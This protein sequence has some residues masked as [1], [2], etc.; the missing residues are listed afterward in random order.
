[1]E[2]ISIIDYARF[3]GL[4]ALQKGLTITPL[5]LQKLLYYEQAWSMVFFGRSA[6]LF[7]EKPQAW[8]NG[9]VYPEI[10]HLFN[11]K[12]GIYDN[13]EKKH[14]CDDKDLDL[15][16][17]I[18]IRQLAESMALNE[19]QLFLSERILTL[20]GTKSQDE[21]VLMTHCEE[22]WCEQREGLL[23]FERCEREISLDTMYRYYKTRH[24]HNR[25]KQ[26]SNV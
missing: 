15:P 8:V 16:M 17:D 22:P 21:L 25:L 7:E 11:H 5:K 14:F 10:Y 26:S 9:P 12:L 6:Q 4:S 3:I 18:C 2:Y 20:Y 19:N 13:F 23:P 1:M 24:E